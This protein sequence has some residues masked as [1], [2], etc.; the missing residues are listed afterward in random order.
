MVIF[1][2]CTHGEAYKHFWQL[3]IVSGQA[4]WIQLH[5]TGMDRDIGRK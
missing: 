3:Q 2:G 5:T 1:G 4:L